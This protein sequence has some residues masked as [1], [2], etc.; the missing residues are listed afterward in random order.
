M[1]TDVVAAPR[2]GIACAVEAGDYLRANEA[3]TCTITWRADRDYM[4]TCAHCCFA[5]SRPDDPNN[6][7]GADCIGLETWDPARRL[8]KRAALV[9]RWSG[10]ATVGVNRKDDA[11]AVLRAGFTA[12]H[13]RAGRRREPIIRVAGFNIS[14]AVEYFYVVGDQER[15]CRN[16]VA[17]AGGDPLQ[18]VL[19][20]PDGQVTA[21]YSDFHSLTMVDQDVERGNSG[22]GIYRRIPGGLE[23]AGILFGMLS[24]R[25]ALAFAS[26]SIAARHS[27]PLA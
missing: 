23:W 9:D 24:P 4:I 25:I 12:E 27:V 20:T 14:S 17:R 22:A 1:H 18:V 5:P 10:I 7:R 21:L 13:L 6:C 3:A 8:H 11:R 16:P 26:P 19:T 2:Q 15:R